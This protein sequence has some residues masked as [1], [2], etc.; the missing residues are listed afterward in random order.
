[1]QIL[2]SNLAFCHPVEQMLTQSRREIRPLNFRHHSPKV[3][4][5]SSFFKLSCSTGSLDSVSRV[6]KA[7]NRSF[8]ASFDA[9]PVSIKSTSTRLALVFSVLASAFTRFAIRAGIDTLCRTAF[10]VLA[11]PHLTPLCTTMPGAA[12]FGFKGCGF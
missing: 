9:R 5:A 1:I 11:M 7:K 8:S 6:V 2:G 3:I 4:R 12:A 10:S